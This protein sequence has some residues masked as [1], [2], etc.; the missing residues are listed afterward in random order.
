MTGLI[1]SNH[2]ILPTPLFFVAAGRR[3]RELFSNDVGRRMSQMAGFDR[4]LQ[5]Q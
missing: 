1:S 5:Y 3:D 4:P 2:R